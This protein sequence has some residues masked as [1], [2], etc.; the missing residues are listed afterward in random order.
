MKGSGLADNGGVAPARLAETLAARIEEVEIEFHRAYWDSQIEASEESDR[1]RVELELELRRIKGDSAALAAVDSALDGDIHDP[2]LKRQLEVLKLSFTGNQM[3]ED[4]RER[5]VSLSSS[6]ESDFASFRPV[7]D[8]RKVSDNEIEEVLR[9]SDDN[10]ERR[11]AWEASKEVGAV[12]AG[13]VRELARLRNQ[14]AHNLG[15]PDHY[16]MSLALQEIDEGWLY[17]LFDELAAATED[18]FTGWKQG[19]DEQLAKRFGTSELYPW[20]YAD[21]FFQSLPPDGRV[22][23][24]PFLVDASAP[25]LAVR[26]FAEWKIDLGPVMQVSDLFP[27]PNKC[28]HAFCLD[29]DRTGKDVRILANVVPGEHWTEVMLHESGHAA[30]DISIDPQLPYLLRR[31]SHI[32]VTEAAALLSG[33]FVRDPIWLE[34]IA[35]IDRAKVAEKADDLRKANATQ[36]LLFARWCMVMTHFERELY[37][38]PEA[39]LDA[40]WWDLVEKYQ[41]VI[42]PPGRSTPDWAAKIHLA[43]A[44]VY[45]HNYLLGDI[46]ASQLSST[47]HSDLGGLLGVPEAGEFLVDRLFRPGN[48]L[49]WDALIEQATGRSLGA[50][51]LAADMQAHL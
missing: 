46:L 1:R 5:I 11:E 19:L 20:H 4:E 8:G 14:A 47:I 9:S 33:R 24:D 36:A 50:N 39:D 2:V 6:V 21:P 45:Y 43:V 30:Y 16:R 42:R 12:V 22:T 29:V 25:E 48:R 10:D 3:D 18:A 34:T 7:L 23:L 32:F 28:Q 40:R 51:D 27:R 49:R 38:D 44:P 13:R 26:T 41:Q 31:A 37:S 35:G 15:F 17:G